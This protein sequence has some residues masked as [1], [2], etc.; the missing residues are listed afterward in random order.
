MRVK[1][2]AAFRTAAVLPMDTQEKR[3][4]ELFGSV[5]EDPKLRQSIL[6]GVILHNSGETIQKVLQVINSAIKDLPLE[7]KNKK[8]FYEV[9]DMQGLSR[10]YA[11]RDT[12]EKLKTSE[13]SIRKVS[14]KTDKLAFISYEDLL[15]LKEQII[16]ITA[17]ALS[18]ESSDT[19]KQQVVSVFL[20]KKIFQELLSRQKIT[21]I[22][23]DDIFH[24]KQSPDYNSIKNFGQVIICD[25]SILLT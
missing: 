22:Y 16:N 21:G 12:A 2:L 1:A 5:V 14:L 4:L 10:Y 20:Y 24:L 9:T 18:F 17:P 25:N 8:D 11:D 15:K 6:D 3:E 23:T 7:I 19:F 13:D